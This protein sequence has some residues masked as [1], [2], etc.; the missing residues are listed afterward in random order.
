MIETDQIG[1]LLIKVV[2][3]RPYVVCTSKAGLNQASMYFIAEQRTHSDLVQIEFSI[4][5]VCAPIAPRVA[6]N[7]PRGNQVIQMACNSYKEYLP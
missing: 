3:P 6:G 1:E 7:V 5:T 2:E 4:D